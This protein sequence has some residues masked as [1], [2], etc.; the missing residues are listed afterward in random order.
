MTAPGLT[1]HD[2]Q[3]HEG[4]PEPGQDGQPGPSQPLT[5]QATAQPVSRQQ[6][7]HRV[8]GELLDAA[9]A[10][11]LPPI[12]WKVA[13]FAAHLTGRCTAYP[14]PAHRR[15]EFEAWRTLLGARATEDTTHGQTVRLTAR[16]ER[17][18]GL[19]TVEIIADL[20]DDLPAPLTTPAPDRTWR[21]P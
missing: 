8:L 7:A 14:G 18:N 2:Q 20:Y 13:A 16:A 21:S 5:V 4:N 6:L 12:D 3:R 9:A 19:V 11:D 10:H 17:D 1:E 15:A